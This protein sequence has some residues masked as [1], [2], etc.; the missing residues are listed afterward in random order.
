VTSILNK[1]SREDG[2]RNRDIMGFTFSEYT[3]ERLA[4]SEFNAAHSMR[5]ISPIYS[6]RYYLPMPPAGDH[7]PEKFYMAHFFD[8]D[9]YGRNDGLNRYPSG[10]FVNLKDG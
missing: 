8:H 9:L 3:G 10:G 7:W 1:V 6:L 2:Y 4:I 5:K